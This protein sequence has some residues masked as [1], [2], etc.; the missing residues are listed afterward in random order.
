MRSPSRRA[1]LIGTA[2]AASL[3]AY[4]AIASPADA[5]TGEWR[6]WAATFSR[7]G[8]PPADLR[9]VTLRAGRAGLTPADLTGV[10]LPQPTAPLTLL[11]GDWW[12]GSYVAVQ[13]HRLLRG[14]SEADT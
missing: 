10:N 4:P 7:S 9:A 12:A 13:P 11:F 1:L 3:A 14:C 8:I 2:A 6:E 5:L